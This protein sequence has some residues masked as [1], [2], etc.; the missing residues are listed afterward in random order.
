[1]IQHAIMANKDFVVRTEAEVLYDAD[2]QIRSNAVFMLFVLSK[3]SEMEGGT[4]YMDGCPSKSEVELIVPAKI[5]KVVFTRE[6]ETSD[7]MC[8]LQFLQQEG[9]S[10]V[11]NDEI[12]L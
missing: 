8:A 1:M 5:A 11:L 9:I 6:P 4:L 7:E 2:L 12:I 3:G 10:T